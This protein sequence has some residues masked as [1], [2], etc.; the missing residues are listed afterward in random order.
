MIADIAIIAVLVVAAIA[1]VIVAIAL[2]MRWRRNRFQ[3]SLR[4]M[5][6]SFAVLGCALFV[7]LRWIAPAVAHRWAIENIYSSG[8]AILFRDDFQSGSANIY[9][10]PSTA[11]PW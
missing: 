9:S 3:F 1:A 7:I 4:T 8:G 6:V 10:D 5:L 2:L 11:N